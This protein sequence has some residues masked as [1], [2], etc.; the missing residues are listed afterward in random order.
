MYHLTKV[1]TKI[2]KTDQK[3]KAR[4]NVKTSGKEDKVERIPGNE[5]GVEKAIRRRSKWCLPG[6]KLKTV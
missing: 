3:W 1:W 2:R 4:D 6:K 5:S